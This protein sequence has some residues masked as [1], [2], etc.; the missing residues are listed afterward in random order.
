MTQ[1]RCRGETT[2]EEMNKGLI[3]AMR[4]H[5]PSYDEKKIDAT[6]AVYNITPLLI[7]VVPNNCLMLLSLCS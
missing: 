3:Q 1:Q 6:G 2:D 7:V 5:Q 4:Q